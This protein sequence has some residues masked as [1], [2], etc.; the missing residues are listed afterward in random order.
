M[1]FCIAFNIYK[2]KECKFIVFM[3]CKCYS[4]KYISV[5]IYC[6][7]WICKTKNC[8]VLG[9]YEVL[10]SGKFEPTTAADFVHTPVNRSAPTFASLLQQPTTIYNLIYICFCVILIYFIVQITMIYQSVILAH[11][12]LLW[13]WNQ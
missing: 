9:G 11:S 4:G 8:L 12:F 6:W 1:H 5:T 13:L 7:N 3:C 10:A 2:I